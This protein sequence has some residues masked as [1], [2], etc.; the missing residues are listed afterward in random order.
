[1]EP[2]Y[3]SPEFFFPGT[4]EEEPPYR[5]G[6]EQNLHQGGLDGIDPAADLIK[7]A[8]LT[9]AIG[10]DPNDLYD[11]SLDTRQDIE[12]NLPQWGPPF[13]KFVDERITHLEK[14]VQ[15]AT[16]KWSFQTQTYVDFASM[17]TNASGNIDVGTNPN[18]NLIDV[19]PGFTAALHR[20][21]IVDVAHNLGT[22]Y[23]N[24]GSWWELRIDGE[25]IFGNSMISGQGQLPVF[26]TWGTRDAPRIRDGELATLF[27]SGGPAS[28]ML[29]IRMQWSY[30]RTIE[31]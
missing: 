18:A 21:S 20:L 29:K 14:Q 13:V 19:P 24:P 3:P 1:M 12:K 15:K 23:T 31:G 5:E 11:A 26:V 22:P 6:N 10:F 9:G 4:F 16:E 30:D 17:N 27:M 25:T 7:S 2:I 28:T 8:A